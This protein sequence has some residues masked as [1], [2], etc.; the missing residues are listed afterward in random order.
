MKG[1]VIISGCF[2][3][4]VMLNMIDLVLLVIIIM[5]RYMETLFWG[6]FAAAFAILIGLKR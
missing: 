6:L 1:N 2:V 3:G 5:V 4:V